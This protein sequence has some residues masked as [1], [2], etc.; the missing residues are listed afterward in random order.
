VVLRSACTP[1]AVT[2]LQWWMSR[3]VSEGRLLTAR[4]PSSDT[5]THQARS[6]DVSAVSLLTARIPSS[7]IAFQA[8][9]DTSLNSSEVI[10]GKR[11]ART[12]FRRWQ[13]HHQLV[14]PP[15]ASPS[16]H[17]G[18]SI[19]CTPAIS[20]LRPRTHASSVLRCDLLSIL[21]LL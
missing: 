12:P 21:Q 16:C 17:G 19:H 18:T 4:S 6:R 14:S 9:L 2:R 10:A 15:P 7:V 5:K 3:H 8:W 13:A 11:P 1:A 20:S